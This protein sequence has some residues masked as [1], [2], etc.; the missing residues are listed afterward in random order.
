MIVLDA[1]AA[2]EWV[3]NTAIGE[4]VGQRIAR[5]STLHAPHLIDLEVAQ[6]LRRFLRANALAEPRASAA[7]NDFV[8]LDIERYDH[9]PLL[10]RIWQLRENLTAY[11]A[12]YVALAEALNVPLLTT[13]GKLAGAPGILCKVDVVS[14]A[15][16]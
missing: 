7:L 11:D 5:Q 4:M 12:A 8:Q 6:T 15:H 3:L 9:S 16:T 1:S 2:V 10:P 13:D 14:G